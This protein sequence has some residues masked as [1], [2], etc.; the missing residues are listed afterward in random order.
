[1]SDRDKNLFLILISVVL[2]LGYV[3][4]V[5]APLRKDTQFTHNMVNRQL[6]RMETRARI[7][8]PP[9]LSESRLAEKLDDLEAD[10]RG[11]EVQVGLLEE[12]FVSLDSV[13]GVKALRLEIASLAE[14]AG[15][16][17]ERFGEVD[18]RAEV[19]DSLS[20]LRKQIRAPFGRPV[21]TFEA[22]GG[23][24]AIM[25]FVE[26]LG[27]LDRSAAILRMEIK[28]PDF[29]DDPD[30]QELTTD[31]RARFEIAL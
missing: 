14:W 4:A 22:R 19:A 31:L 27:R 9:E 24:G 26:S 25:Q 21:L 11:L 30:L 7:P 13:D 6:N 23:F 10:R 5:Y 16:D 17:V 1:M 20:A 15:L 3:F 2:I 8:D 18:E 29:H 28:A 12:R